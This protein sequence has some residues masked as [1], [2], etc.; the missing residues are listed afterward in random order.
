[1]RHVGPLDSHRGSSP[2]ARDKL[3]DHGVF[4]PLEREQGVGERAGNR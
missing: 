1:M 4:D 2:E 3:I